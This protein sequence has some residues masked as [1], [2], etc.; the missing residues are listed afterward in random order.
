[1]AVSLH[2]TA[3]DGPA[4]N[5]LGIE[6]VAAVRTAA[7]SM[8][9]PIELRTMCM[10]GSLIPSTRF[11][12]SSVS[13]PSSNC[14]GYFLPGGVALLQRGHNAAGGLLDEVGSAQNHVDH[15]GRDLKCCVPAQE[16]QES[17]QARRRDAPRTR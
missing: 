6:A 17:G 16:F 5:L 7:A 2:Q 13:S 11:F 3:F 9:W 14:D 15:V 10:M 8:P 4:E 12:S 1:M